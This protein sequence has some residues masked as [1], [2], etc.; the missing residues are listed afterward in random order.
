[1]SD[2]SVVNRLTAL[3]TSL[4]PASR[5]ALLAGLEAMSIDG[6]GGVVVVEIPRNP[7]HDPEVSFLAGRY[8]FNLADRRH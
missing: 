3:V 5:W 6:V 1:M 2:E 8:E 7:K 4:R